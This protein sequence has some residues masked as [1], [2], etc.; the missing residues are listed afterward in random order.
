MDRC[1]GLSLGLVFHGQSIAT[2]RAVPSVLGP[3]DVSGS[4]CRSGLQ[5]PGRNSLAIGAIKTGI[6]T[7]GVA[8]RHAAPPGVDGPP[9]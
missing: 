7:R 1:N 6:F 2:P 9:E 4:P 5:Y 3:P 8:H